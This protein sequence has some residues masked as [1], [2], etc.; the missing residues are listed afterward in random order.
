[1]WCPYTSGVDLRILRHGFAHDLLMNSEKLPPA[2]LRPIRRSPFSRLNFSSNFR[3]EQAEGM[4]LLLAKDLE[5]LHAR[6]ASK[7]SMKARARSCI[8]LYFAR[9]M[10][11]A[12]LLCGAAS[13]QKELPRPRAGWAQWGSSALPPLF[14]AGSTWEAL[15]AASQVLVRKYLVESQSRSQSRDVASTR[16]SSLFSS[17]TLVKPS[18]P[19]GRARRSVTKAPKSWMSRARMSDL[20]EG[21]VGRRRG[22]GSSCIF[23]LRFLYEFLK[24]IRRIPI[25]Y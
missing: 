7:G 23:H 6:L 18:T 16:H 8:F 2:S 25:N 1:M 24:L 11:R 4:N 21:Q 19:P 13:S 20:R 10:S 3:E 17:P 15:A 9:S 14:E 5:H 12:L 22:A